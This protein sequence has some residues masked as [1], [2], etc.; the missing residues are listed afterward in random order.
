MSWV[1]LY[2]GR[3]F[4]TLFLKLLKLKEPMKDSEFEK[5]IENPFKKPGV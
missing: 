2:F 1:A 3:W 5:T 4:Y